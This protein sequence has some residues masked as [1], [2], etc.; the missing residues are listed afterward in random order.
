MGSNYLIEDE[1][2]FNWD[3]KENRRIWTKKKAKKP[4]IVKVIIAFTCKPKHFLASWNV[5]LRV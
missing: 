2:W 1:S 3:A 4:K 5:N